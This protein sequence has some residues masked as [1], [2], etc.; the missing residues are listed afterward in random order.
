MKGPAGALYHAVAGEI[1]FRAIAE[2]AACVLGCS[3]CSVSLAEAE[4]IWGPVFVQLAL[5]V[6][7]RSRAPRARAELGWKPL[8][9]DLIEDIRNGSYRA[10]YGNSSTGRTGNVGHTGDLCDTYAHGNRGGKEHA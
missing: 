3:A 5:A 9:V 8:N 6:N 2:A 1:N 10:A 7:S 4:K